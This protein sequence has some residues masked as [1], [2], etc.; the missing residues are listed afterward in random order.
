MEDE[1]VQYS[2]AVRR[3]AAAARHLEEKKKK[4]KRV[5]G[6]C[7]RRGRIVR[8]G[9]GARSATS[10]AVGLPPPVDDADL[11]FAVRS[12]STLPQLGSR[13]ID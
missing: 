2:Y 5:W 4:K 3:M 1:Y 12:T 11:T 13:A 10:G 7:T 8:R 6:H 9:C